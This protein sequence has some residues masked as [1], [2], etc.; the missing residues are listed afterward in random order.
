M[1][2]NLSALA[3]AGQQFFDDSG[4]PL[5]GGKLYSY[6]AGT[7]T[8]QAT[9]TSA[10]GA[11]AHTNPIVLNSA[12]RVATGEIWLTASQNY[13]FVLKTSTEVTIATWDNITGINGTGIT[14]NAAS[15][16]YDPPFTG[17]V[18]ISVETKL[19]Q[20]INVNDFGADPTGVVSS[21][22]A[23]AAA[24][25]AVDIGG[26][27]YLDGVYKTTEEI[28]ITKTLS[29]VGQDARV[30]NVVNPY[31]SRSCI[32][33]ESAT[34]AAGILVDNCLGTFKNFVIVNGTTTPAIRVD[35]IRCQGGNAS[36]KIYDLLVEGFQ[37]GIRS[38]QNYYN[39]IENTSIA[40][41]DECLR[42]DNCYNVQLTGMKLRVNNAPVYA[43]ATYGLMLLNGSQVNVFGGAIENFNDA[44]VYMPDSNNSV[45]LFGVYFES[46]STTNSSH[47]VQA[48][49]YNS[50]VAVACHV[51]MT[52]SERFITIFGGGNVGVRVYSRNNRIVYPTNTKVVDLYVRQSGDTTASW[53]V[54][55][56]NWQ[57]PIGANVTY[58]PNEGVGGDGS[59]KIN[60]PVGHPLF[61]KPVNSTPYVQN[62][63]AS[64]PTLPVSVQTGTV[65]PT[66][67]SFAN[68]SG[69][70]ADDPLGLHLTTWGYFPYMTVYQKGQWEKVGTRLPNQANST[71]ATLA[72][73][74]TD[75]NALLTKLRNNG[76]M[77]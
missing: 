71:A 4:N 1:T 32:I 7:T 42:F 70:S 58:F 5:S 36:V 59:L 25:A 56:D 66:L 14:T 73:L 55:G 68:Q 67:V 35:G 54:A 2:V 48:G 16:V 39:V 51:Y 72:D 11:T 47:V 41:C 37:T 27:I 18:A 22:T 64:A 49:N 33:T 8:P 23:F 28:L 21:S 13:K 19:A 24:I 15:V 9:Y 12:G 75:F 62:A 34:D 20:I 60:Y 26:T 3:G 63:W 52:H 30:G 31:A 57:S 43:S 29:I 69:T 44:A 40:F 74:V 50:V 53:D 65:L 17:S 38:T 61:L 45:A 76:V 6:A 77:I 46:H 10:S